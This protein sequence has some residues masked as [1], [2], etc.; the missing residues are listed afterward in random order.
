MCFGS[1]DKRGFIGRIGG[2]R[3]FEGANLKGSECLRRIQEYTRPIAAAILG[4][5]PEELTLDLDQTAG[6]KPPG[7][8]RLELHI[9]GNRRGD[10]QIAI[11]LV[12]ASF[13]VCIRSHRVQGPWQKAKGYYAMNKDD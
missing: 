9:D 6:V 11:A 5:L 8:E 4:V 7:A 12:D 10:V 13:L 1:I 2:G 3:L